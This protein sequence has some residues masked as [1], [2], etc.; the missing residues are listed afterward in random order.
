MIITRAPLRITLGGG[1][2]DLPSY[3]EE[4]GGFCA[5]AAINQYVYIAIN[6]NFTDKLIVK[7]SE[8]EIVD[9]AQQLK[10]PII[11][12]CFG[13]VGLSGRGME[14]SCFADIPA[15]TGLGSSSSFTCALLKALYQWD[16][17]V[18][19]A[20]WIAERACDIEITCLRQP[21]GK[22]DQ[23]IAAYGGAMMMSFYKDNVILS[24]LM[25]SANTKAEMENK[26]LL[27]YTGKTRSANDI[28]AEQKTM[29]LLRDPRMLENLHAV[30]KMG[31]YCCDSL[32]KGDLEGFARTM[33]I[34]W[35]AKRER[36]ANMSNDEINSVYETAK[37][38]GGVIGGKLIGAGGGGFLMMYTETPQALRQL[39]V[40][41]DLKEVHF[42]FDYDGTKTLY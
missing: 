7:Y 17:S 20:R 30:K 23:Y 36:S 39:L 10:H 8:T 12:E 27:F 29:T 34:H 3:Y 15:G 28:L 26:L 18:V 35:A 38:H 11:R 6:K 24:P 9:D 1:G 21:I 13:L 32:E 16:D 22:Q 37:R 4:F 33:D 25:L 14:I 42:T 2:T 19:S 40:Q 31:H 5:A 41:F